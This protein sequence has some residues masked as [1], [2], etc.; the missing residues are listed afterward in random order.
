MSYVFE[1]KD[2]GET[3]YVLG[4]EIIQNCPKMHVSKCL[5]MILDL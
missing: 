2:M 1:M 3:R 5:E 4:V